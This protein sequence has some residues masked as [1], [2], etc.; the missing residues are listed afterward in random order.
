MQYA[1]FLA[2]EMYLL[3]SRFKR[4]CSA[5]IKGGNY[6]NIYNSTYGICA[7]VTH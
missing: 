4:L 3:T 2:Q 1:V 7:T 5:E 6:T